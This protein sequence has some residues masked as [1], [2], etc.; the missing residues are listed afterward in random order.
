VAGKSPASQ[1]RVNILTASSAI[2]KVLCDIPPFASSFYRL[3][4]GRQDTVPSGFGGVKSSARALRQR[5]VSVF[6]D[7]DI[8]D[9]VRARVSIP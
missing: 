6:D 9:A 3:D 5:A 1:G 2:G 4:R 7:A 8:E